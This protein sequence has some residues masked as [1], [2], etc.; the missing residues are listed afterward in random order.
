MVGKPSSFLPSPDP[1]S[2]AACSPPATPFDAAT[3][4]A[5]AAFAATAVAGVGAE[6][7]PGRG[8]ALSASQIMAAHAPTTSEAR[9]GERV[10][11]VHARLA[12]SSCDSALSVRTANGSTK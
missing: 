12:S 4:P 10:T 2:A 3:A 7:A 9:H 5:G 6:A 1:D 8:T 11:V